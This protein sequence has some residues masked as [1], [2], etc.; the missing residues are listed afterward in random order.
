M[1]TKVHLL[2]SKVKPVLFSVGKIGYPTSPVY[3]IAYRE[4]ST[5]LIMLTC[6]SHRLSLCTLLL[7]ANII[8]PVA[9]QASSLP[10]TDE[11]AEALGSGS[12][13]RIAGK[14][15]ERASQRPI[16]EATIMVKCGDRVLANRQSNH[17][18]EFVLYIPPEKI[19]EQ[20]ISI[21]I[22][23][24]NHIFIKDRIE[25]ISQEMLIEIN[26]TVLFETHPIEDY[27]MPIHTLGEPTVGR[28]LIRTRNLYTKPQVRMVKTQ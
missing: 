20:E 3:L 28:V 23:Y 25:P 12:M 5:L 18:G 21:K 2:I 6:G 17:D 9:S 10:W 19:S 24:R 14:L 4:I 8:L 16:R 27:R 26:G 7:F 1:P 11:D 13:V 15:V 22:K